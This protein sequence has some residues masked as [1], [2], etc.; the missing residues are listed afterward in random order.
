MYVHTNRLARRIFAQD[1]KATQFVLLL[2][3]KLKLIDNIH[4]LQIL[5]LKFLIEH[6]N[7]PQIRGGGI[8]C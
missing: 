7:P 8:F 4:C 2:F 1:F 3:V 6:F 5:D